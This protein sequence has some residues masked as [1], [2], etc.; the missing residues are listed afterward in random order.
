MAGLFGGVK[1]TFSAWNKADA[2]GLTGMQR[3]GN[4]GSALQGQGPMYA[5]RPQGEPA[6]QAAQQQL[7]FAGRLNQFGAQMQDIGDQNPPPQPQAPMG[8]LPVNAPGL[9]AMGQQQNAMALL[10]RLYGGRR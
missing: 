4:L 10:Q 1:S 6:P 8:H 2:N 5:A 3:L 9:P 7:G